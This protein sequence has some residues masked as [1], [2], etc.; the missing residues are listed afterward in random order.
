MH[1]TSLCEAQILLCDALAY[2]HLTNP[3][4]IHFT[5][6]LHLL[7]INNFAHILIFSELTFSHA[8]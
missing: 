3:L 8:I 1:A 4:A 7:L 6:N 5:Y 2:P